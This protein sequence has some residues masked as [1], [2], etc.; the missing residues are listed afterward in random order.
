[1]RRWPRPKI[2]TCTSRGGYR[3]RCRGSCV[4]VLLGPGNCLSGSTAKTLTRARTTQSRRG[5]DDRVMGL[6]DME[7]RPFGCVVCLVCKNLRVKRRVMLDY[8]LNYCFSSC[9]WV[10]VAAVVV[11]LAYALLRVFGSRERVRERER[12]LNMYI[13]V[14][15]QYL[16]SGAGRALLHDEKN[17]VSSR[18]FTE[19]CIFRSL[20]WCNQGG[21]RIVQPSCFLM[22]R[23]VPLSICDIGG[24][25]TTDAGW[26]CFKCQQRSKVAIM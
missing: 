10:L 3:G 11:V 15:F 24:V 21:M 14:S 13:R 2:P 9:F 6:I 18:L 25:G 19:I 4:S 16:K 20:L 7:G 12:E 17:V 5:D 22:D 8:L 26:F 1:M 23:L